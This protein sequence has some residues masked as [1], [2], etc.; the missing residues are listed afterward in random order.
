M[1]HRSA[2]ISGRVVLAL[3]MREMTTRYTRLAGGYLWAVL[4]PVAAI[5]LLALVFSQA[6]RAPPIGT[7]FALFYATGYLPFMMFNDLANKTAETVAF[8]RQLLFYPVVTMADALLAR[9]FLNLLTHLLVFAIVIVGIQLVEDVRVPFD[10]PALALGLSL[11]A[12]LGFGI[13]CLNCLL[14]AFLPIWPQIWGVMM[15]PMFLISCILF[16][17]ETVPA[18]YQA[19]LWYNPLVHP[20]GFVRHSTFPT[21]MADY[22]AAG[23]PLLLA[24]TCAAAGL[25][26]LTRYRSRI[27]NAP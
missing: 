22:A 26:F 16:T 17:F 4:E 18:A 11:A 23:Y 1:A 12:V 14:N 25:F 15:R 19:V 27:L 8:N 5:T 24:M 6:F 20:I 13:G 10:F 7:S 9:F 3:M 2:A 21:Y